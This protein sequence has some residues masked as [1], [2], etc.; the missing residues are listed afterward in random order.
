MH[1]SGVFNSEAESIVACADKLIDRTGRAGMYWND[2]KYR[3][4]CNAMKEIKNGE[5]SLRSAAS[6]CAASVDAFWNIAAEQV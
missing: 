3:E 4:L 6:A 1:N 5:S 2:R